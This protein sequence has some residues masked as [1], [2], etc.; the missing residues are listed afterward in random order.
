MKNKKILL[1]IS[2]IISLGSQTIIA[3]NLVPDNSFETGTSW[4][5]KDNAYIFYSGNSKPD[6]QLFF[7][8]YDP[9]SC[10]PYVDDISLGV[11]DNYFG[12]ETAYTGQ[13]YAGLYS[14][15]MPSG[16]GQYSSS[17][18]EQGWIGI[19]LTQN[20]QVDVPYII[21]F[22][23]SKMDNSTKNPEYKVF[24]SKDVNNN[25]PDDIVYE[26]KGHVLISNGWENI[27]FEYT[28]DESGV[29]YIFFKSKDYSPLGNHY[30]TGFYLDEVLIIDKCTYDGWNCS[31]VSGTL[32]PG[33]TGMHYQDAPVAIYDM[34]NA[35]EAWIDV[36]PNQVSGSPIRSYYIKS[37]NGITE[38]FYWDGKNADYAE[39]AAGIFVF[40]VRLINHCDDQTFELP[41]V[42]YNAANNPTINVTQTSYQAEG[43]EIPIPNCSPYIYPYKLS[44]EGSTPYEYYSSDIIR[45][46]DDVTVEDGADVLFQA[47]NKIILSEGFKVENGGLF[48]AIIDDYSKF[49]IKVDNSNDGMISELNDSIKES[50]FNVFPNPSEGDMNIIY[51]IH[52]TEIGTFEIYD[53]LGGKLY[54]RSIYGG[55]HCIFISDIG[56]NQGVYIYKAFT[57][58]KFIASDKIVVIK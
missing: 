32:D 19:E 39:Q 43:I 25:E 9:S 57:N 7:D 23:V 8:S 35:I 5:F 31:T 13:K 15:R 17:P 36:Y 49:I 3:Q 55:T 48:R 24:L 30:C 44:F 33:C 54:T 34:D 50:I 58:N 21:K 2:V 38:P 53:L 29:N 41:F 46:G 12:Y 1:I 11:P 16:C 10:V 26:D 28:P 14:H 18:N 27:Q 6:E 51:S 47:A 40:D 42:K 22:K 20:L 56:L 52:E 4:I 37:Y 45:T